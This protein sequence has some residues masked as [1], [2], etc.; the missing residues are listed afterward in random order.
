MSRKIFLFR[1][2]KSNKP[3]W[4]QS[5]SSPCWW[6]LGRISFL[7]LIIVLSIS[8]DGIYKIFSLGIS[9]AFFSSQVFFTS[10]TWPSQTRAGHDIWCRNITNT[11]RQPGPRVIFKWLNTALSIFLNLSPSLCRKIPSG[12]VGWP[13][14]L[15]IKISA[16]EHI[17]CYITQTYK[18]L[19]SLP[20]SFQ[21]FVRYLAS[22]Q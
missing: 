17:K 19:C 8:L 21:D 4:A 3:D 12:S 15:V 18:S 16:P 20:F 6:H 5:S 22:N 9:D 10:W 2:R 13:S 1:N 7:F 11:C 14:N